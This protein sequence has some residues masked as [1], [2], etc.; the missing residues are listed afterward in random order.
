MPR[1]QL[2]GGQHIQADTRQPI[3]PRTGKHPSQ[4]F[5]A[6]PPTLDREGKVVKEGVFPVFESNAAVCANDW[7]KYKRLN[8]GVEFSESAVAV[9][10]APPRFLAAELEAMTL[11]QLRELAAKENIDVDGATTK[12]VII[13]LILAEC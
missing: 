11:A 2:L 3:N 1:Y 5:K 10:D 4:V 9:M 13:R 8:D 12:G 6:F 7:R